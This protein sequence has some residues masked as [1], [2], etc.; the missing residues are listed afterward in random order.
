ML[1]FISL[2]MLSRLLNIHQVPR[3]CTSLHKLQLTGDLSPRQLYFH[4][5]DPTV[6]RNPRL[7]MNN[8]YDI[9]VYEKS[10]VTR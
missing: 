7:L 5:I 4:L 2:Q 10:L 9:H 3:T 8:P 6:T 1:R